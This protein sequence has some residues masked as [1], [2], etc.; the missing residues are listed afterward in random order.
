MITLL[1]LLAAPAFAGDRD[2]DGLDDARDPCPDHA[3]GHEAEQV[4]PD[5][6]LPEHVCPDGTAWRRVGVDEAAQSGGST[7]EAHAPVVAAPVA[8]AVTP[9][10][11]PSSHRPRLFSGQGTPWTIGAGNGAVGLGRPL[12]VGVGEVTDVTIGTTLVVAL[13]APSVQVKR[14]LHDDGARAFALTGEASVPTWG[15]RQLQTGFLQPILADQTVPMAGVL[16]LTGLAGWRREDLVVSAGLRLR[17]G[18]PL[19]DG[20]V[21]EQDAAW[22]DPAL[23]PLSEGWSLQ[24]LARVDWLPSPSWQLSAQGRVEVAGGLELQ[25]KFGA[26][27]SVGDHVALGLG[28][29]GAVAR[30]TWGW[31]VPAALLQQVYPT[32]DVQARW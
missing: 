24:P 29:N 26:L 32:A 17:A 16:G 3:A 25:G 22:L 7:M 5:V 20:T 10:A 6:A 23:A 2:G 12:T 15:F 11:G 14:T 30:E 8:P 19:E 28:V 27:R 9:G 1:S 18:V 31:S 13:L 21:T 4:P